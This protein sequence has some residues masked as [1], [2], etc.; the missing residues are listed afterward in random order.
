MS[1]G[2]GRFPGFAFTTALVLSA[3]VSSARAATLH[4]VPAE[5][6]VAVEV[7]GAGS[8][9]GLSVYAEQSPGNAVPQMAGKLIIPPNGGLRF[10]PQFPFVRGVRYRAEYRPE[11]GPLV[12]S[13]FELPADTAPPSTVVSQ[14]YP[15][16]ELLPEN[17]LKFYVQFSAPMSRGQ[18]YEHVRIRDAAGRVIALAFLELDEELWDPSMTRLTLLIDPGRIK[19]GVKPLEDIGPVFEAGKAY[20]LTV[21]AA[22]RDAEDRPLRAGAEKKFRIAPADRTAPEL[23]RW[24]VTPPAVG[25]RA[26]LTV[27]FGEPMDHALASRVLSVVPSDGGALDGTVTLSEQERVWNFVP[28]QP[29]RAGGHRLVIATTLEDLAGNNIGKPFDVDVF[30]NVQ[31]RI[32]TPTVELAFSIK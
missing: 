27:G 1:L 26:A 22:C 29:W 28:N 23:A 32:E 18:I 21:S 11:K 8:D 9:W 6:P 7:R 25:T 13:Y 24:V 10:V 31:R 20:A 3:V 19:R 5:R 15:T 4:W 12:V 2:G 16:S 30:E 14:I 17:Q